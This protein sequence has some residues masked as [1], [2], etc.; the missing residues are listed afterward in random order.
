[1]YGTGEKCMIPK[2]DLLS[3]TDQQLFLKLKNSI[4]PILIRGSKEKMQDNY[5]FILAQITKYVNAPNEDYWKRALVCGLV[6]LDQRLAL[7]TRQLQIVIN[8]CKSSINAGFQSIG[9]HNIA[10]EPNDVSML[11]KIFPFLKSNCTEARQWT[12]REFRPEPEIPIPKTSIARFS[13]FFVPPPFDQ[14]RNELS[15]IPFSS[16]TIPPLKP[17]LPPIRSIPEMNSL[18]SVQNQSRSNAPFPACPNICSSLDKI[19]L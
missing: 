11:I 10:T 4:A 18:P 15:Q 14:K 8:R 19:N 9:F 5:T 13:P 1:M 12:I 2:F 16:M 17:Q 7:N 3:P 6:W